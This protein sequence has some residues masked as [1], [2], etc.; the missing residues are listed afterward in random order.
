MNI[1]AAG[2]Q[3]TTGQSA[4]IDCGGAGTLRAQVTVTATA[5]AG[6]VVATIQTSHDA[7]VTDAWRTA[8]AAFAS[9]NS[10]V[11]SPYQVMVIDRFVRVNYAIS[12]TSVTFDVHG[13]AV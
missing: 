2:L 5:G 10:A 3:T 4:A 6:A 12:G 7:G 1:L 13:E 9:I 8:G 11:S